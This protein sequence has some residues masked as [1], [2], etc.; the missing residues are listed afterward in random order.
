MIKYSSNSLVRFSIELETGYL[1][2]SSGFIIDL[3]NLK[4]FLWSPVILQF[5]QSNISVSLYLADTNTRSF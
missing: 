4:S 5:Y 3:T 1:T 2:F